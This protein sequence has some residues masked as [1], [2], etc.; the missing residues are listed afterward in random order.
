VQ[1]NNNEGGVS[2]TYVA[3]DSTNGSRYSFINTNVTFFDYREGSGAKA[4]PVIATQIDVAA[5]TN[6]MA[7]GGTEANGWSLNQNLHAINSIYVDEQRSTGGKFSAVR[8]ANGRYLPADGLTI[9]TARPLYVL[10]NYNAPDL[11]V[12][13]TNTASTKP[14][15][16]VADAVTILSTSWTDTYSDTPVSA[17]A[18]PA[19]DTTVNA[20]IISGIVASSS[21]GGT[22]HYSGGAENLLR[23]LEDWS[24]KGTAPAKT[25]T[26]NGSLVV[27]F[28]SR[29]ATSYWSA[30]GAYYN[31][32]ARKWA[33]D[34]N[35]LDPDKLPPGT[36]Q[37][38]KLQ[39]GQWS[40][41]AASE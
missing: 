40:V 38:R 17:N 24:A 21:A 8:V 12:G 23:F 25:L 16:L 35:F 2:L 9:A 36:P 31:P 3:P 4:L 5:L 34:T 29:Y 32:P 14:S 19:G 33:F 7:H 30:S 18:R 13:S 37:A 10:G 28:P 1:F 15:S 11:A 39:R 20:A 6:W 22:K 41:V 27:M 26:Y